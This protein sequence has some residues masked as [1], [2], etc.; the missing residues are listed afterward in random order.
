[1]SIEIINTRKEM[2]TLPYD[3]RVDRMSCL[4]NPFIL[5]Y[6]GNRDEVCDKF[7]VWFD[8]LVNSWVPGEVIMRRK[9]IFNELCRL[10]DLY[11]RCGKFRLF[12][13]CAPKKCHAETIRDYLLD[14]TVVLPSIHDK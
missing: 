11:G 10:A 4:G 2:P 3:V 6:D 7:K 13:W 5:R 9:D 1:M 12:C 8:E 14:K